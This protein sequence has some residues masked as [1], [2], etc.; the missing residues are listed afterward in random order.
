MSYADYFERS[1]LSPF[2]K[3]GTR[4][5]YDPRAP[6]PEQKEEDVV[7]DADS[8]EDSSEAEQDEDDNSAPEDNLIS[9]GVPLSTNSPTETTKTNDDHGM[10]VASP[11][12]SRSPSPV[13]SFASF[14]SD[15][16]L[17]AP[18]DTEAEATL[19]QRELEAEAA[20]LA[21]SSTNPTAPPLKGILKKSKGDEARKKAAKRIREEEEELERRKLMAPR[22]KRKLVEK[23][24]Y[25]N[26]K[27]NAEVE[28]LTGKKRKLEKKKSKQIGGV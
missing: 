16:E 27:K 15:G 18:S 11:S 19:H 26:N 4:G 2:V 22:K 10:T 5:A 7:S 23:M 14:G 20:G 6:L 21:F 24:L 25:S 13:P 28:A 8:L 12:S 3:P 1:H 9:N 17:E